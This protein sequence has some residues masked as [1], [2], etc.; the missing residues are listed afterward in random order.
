M[1][2]NITGYKSGS[3]LVMCKGTLA[4]KLNKFY[5]LFDLLNKE[6]AIKTTLPLEEWPLSVSTEDV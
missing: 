4:D 3:A 1:I 5:T 6:S 2:Q